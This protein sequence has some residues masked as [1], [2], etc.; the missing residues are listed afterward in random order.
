MLANVGIVTPC[1]LDKPCVLRRQDCLRASDF[2]A[3]HR[4]RSA[5]NACAD[6][7]LYRDSRNKSYV[8]NDVAHMRAWIA[9]H[10][11]VAPSVPFVN[12]AARHLSADIAIDFLHRLG[13]RIVVLCVQELLSEVA[14][15]LQIRGLFP[16]L[17]FEIFCQVLHAALRRI[18]LRTGVLLLEQSRCL[19]RL[20]R[21]SLALYDGV[22]HIDSCLHITAVCC[23][24]IKRPANRR[25]LLADS[26][27][28]GTFPLVQGLLP[29]LG[30][31]AA[32]CVTDGLLVRI[33]V[34]G[35]L[36]FCHHSFQRRHHCVR[37]GLCF[38]HRADCAADVFVIRRLLRYLHFAVC[39]LSRR[40]ISVLLFQRFIVCLGNLTGKLRIIHAV[41]IPS[42]LG[43]TT[44]RSI[45]GHPNRAIIRFSC[46]VL[47]L[48]GRCRCFIFIFIKL[49]GV[50]KLSV[51]LFS[52]IRQQVIHLSVDLHGLDEI[53]P[54]G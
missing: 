11:K 20:C 23:I 48:K 39:A 52:Y 22:E 16:V 38:Q 2:A 43:Y 24:V 25:I 40:D 36:S 19:Q 51:Q 15:N 44:I 41:D 29:T 5:L 17:L 27:F 12:E 35:E 21:I 1:R 34:V 45:G 37:R 26:L 28:G 49:D 8:A 50:D 47:V 46:T 33:A 4:V 13:A 7:V 42:I 30:F 32:F 14:V 10:R 18:K 54:A 9:K 3:A 53:L 6:D 31:Y